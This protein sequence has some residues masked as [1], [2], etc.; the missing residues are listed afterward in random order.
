MVGRLQ[1][2]AQRVAYRAATAVGQSD[3]MRDEI[4]RIRIGRDRVDLQF[5]AFNTADVQPV[6]LKAAGMAVPGCQIER[7]FNSEKLGDQRTL[8]IGIL[9]VD[10]ELQ[11][12]VA[13]AAAE[14]AA[15]RSDPDPPCTVTLP[16]PAKIT[17]SP[18]PPKIV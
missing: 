11:R 9:I 13:A 8:G 16:A 10:D 2:M 14:P 5:D 3:I 4:R 1:Q 12:V 7:G 6:D 17:S 15:M 18:G